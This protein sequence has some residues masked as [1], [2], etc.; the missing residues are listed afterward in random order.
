MKKIVRGFLEMGNFRGAV[1]IAKIAI[2]SLLC[3]FMAGKFSGQM[4]N[5][6]VEFVTCYFAVFSVGLL[7]WIDEHRKLA[8][9]EEQE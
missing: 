2:L 3:L 9:E 8:P 1:G 4:P 5:G 7:P 6:V